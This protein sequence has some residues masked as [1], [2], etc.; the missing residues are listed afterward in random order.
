MIAPNIVSLL[1]GF[2]ANGILI[3]NFTGKVTY[4]HA[5]ILCIVFWLIASTILMALV[6]ITAIEFPQSDALIYSQGYWMAVMTAILYFLNALFTSM[7]FFGYLQGLYGPTF[8]LNVEQRSVV[9]QNLALVV[10]IAAGAG[11]VSKTCSF[12]YADSLYFCIVTVLLIGLGDFVP[13]NNL[14]R[15]LVMPYAMIGLLFVGL[16]ISSLRL[17]VIGSAQRLALMR[18][19]EE[20]RQKISGHPESEEAFKMMRKIQ[21]AA[22]NRIRWH[23]L[24]MSSTMFAILWLFLGAFVF[25][26]NERAIQG[27]TYF[28]SVYF[29]F[30]CLLTIGYGD[31]T[32]VSNASKAFF[33]VWSLLAVPLMTIFISN[34][35]DTLINS[36]TQISGKVG[37]LF[38]S[39]SAREGALDKRYRDAAPEDAKGE[40]DKRSTDERLRN[41]FQIMRTLILHIS[42][43]SP[44]NY[45]WEDWQV[46]S[47]VSGQRF[48][49]LGSETPMMLLSDESHFF[50]LQYSEAL[51]KFIA[52]I[53]DAMKKRNEGEEGP[54]NNEVIE[55]LAKNL[56]AINRTEEKAE[57]ARDEEEGVGHGVT[58]GVPKH[59]P[60]KIFEKLGT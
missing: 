18:Q 60:W 41:L 10:W 1:L 28:D 47:R 4:V 42:D 33:V 36:W 45:A 44:K 51:E 32:P 17:L 29:C 7:N 54:S 57:K 48:D 31:F 58:T 13:T 46:L 39:P 59:K 21:R 16:V 6:I 12:T 20:R 22:M 50:L 34:L 26:E 52:S 38:L 8:K 27:W 37:D 3:L 53:F 11:V 30:V 15:A 49:W 40:K 56:E 35:G 5:Q 14:S 2:A 43:Q 19:M 55:E 25:W 24:L 23:N 9:L